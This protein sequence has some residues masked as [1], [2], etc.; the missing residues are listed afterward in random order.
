MRTL[1][2]EYPDYP[3]DAFAIVRPLRAELVGTFGTALWMLQGS[4]LVLL[5]LACANVATLLLARTVGRQTEVAIRAAL[6]AGRIR[7]I[8]EL[9]T[10]CTVLAAAAAAGG[11]SLAW[12]A[13]RLIA[14]LGDA[15][16]PRIAELAPDSSMLLFGI[17][18]SAATALLFGLVPAVLAS[19]GSLA[20]VRAGQS[21]TGARSHH[22][23][24]RALVAAEL[25]LAFVLVFVM[26]LLA[27]SYV[28]VM[29][30]NPG[31]DPEHVLTLS[32]LPDGIHYQ[33]PV[34]RL[35]YFDAVV[36]RMRA[37]PGVV[38]A[39]YANTLPLS[40][41]STSAVYILEHPRVN[42]AEAPYLDT[43]L[44]PKGT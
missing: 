12:V 11:V 40:H 32:L 17:A 41:P 5:V 43:Y 7:L 4:V 27:K 20:T 6:G 28:R 33:T 25:A 14:G 39:G 19:S 24:V 35:G 37:I 1:V 22:A 9:F 44:I 18:M 34:Q 36:D 2:R 26:G 13:T 21:V 38:D 30:V 29:Q 15:N 10:E 42:D 8:R 23:A 31:Y 3:A 16:I